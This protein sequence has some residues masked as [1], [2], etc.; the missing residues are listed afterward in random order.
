MIP[1]ILWLILII[2]SKIIAQEKGTL[3]NPD[4]Y[5]F[6]EFNTGKVGMINGRDLNVV[7]NYN[8]VTE[9]LVFMQKGQIYDMV[10]YSK[11]DTVSLNNKK[12]IP[13]ENM[14]L[15]IAESGRYTLLLQ[16]IGT[17]QSPPKPAAYGGTSEVSSSTYVNYAMMGNEPYRLQNDTTLIIRHEI[18]YWIKSAD[19]LNS[20]L[21][22][23]QLVKIL[24]DY[25]DKIRLYINVNHLKFDNPEHVTRLVTYCNSF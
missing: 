11:I 13:S 2:P 10:E 24:H 5:L 16:H 18:I 7:L 21:N 8:I 23:K 4:Q 12:F 19:K 3:V 9:K 17:I 20:F 6:P 22:E 14:F 15:E 1:A 25:K